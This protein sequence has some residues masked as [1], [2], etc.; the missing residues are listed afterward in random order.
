M[1]N[2]LCLAA[3]FLAAGAFGKTRTTVVVSDLHI[4]V[5][6]CGAKWCPSE[7]FRWPD[8]FAAFLRKI[9]VYGDVDLIFNGDTFELWQSLSRDCSHD[10]ANLGCSEAEALG[11]FIR[12]ADQHSPTLD[13]ILAFAARRDNRVVFVPGNHDAA[14]LYPSV[15]A[16]LLRRVKSDRV[17]V[18][19]EGYWIAPSDGAVYA[20]HGHQIG[21]DPNRMKRWPAPFLRDDGNVQYL[22]K[23]WGEQFVQDFYNAYE[24]RFPA[25]D[26][27]AG[28][29]SGLHYG[30]KKIGFIGTLVALGRFVKF[31]LLDESPE[32]LAQ[33]LSPQNKTRKWDVDATRLMGDELLTKGMG[34][35]TPLG[36][37]LDSQAARDAADVHIASLSK[38]ELTILCNRLYAR[39][40]KGE[41]VPQCVFSPAGLSPEGGLGAIADALLKDRDTKLIERV[42]AVDGQLKQA[43]E[44]RFGVFIYSHTHEPLPKFEL[45]ANGRLVAFAN[46]GA[47][48]HLASGKWAKDYESSHGSHGDVIAQEPEVIPDCF[49]FVVV[50]ADERSFPDLLRWNYDPA[51]GKGTIDRTSC[52]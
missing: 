4:G 9:D 43:A 3:L 11:R 35:D 37:L 42:T 34:E 39:S 21:R 7:D 29:S 15:R 17:S 28:E 52:Q 36:S 33:G 38:S 40:L 31:G 10:D 27:I 46:T 22:Q 20:E 30:F 32:Q 5:G 13:E 16:E 51:T 18:A 19:S 23:T 25:I 50:R 6:R 44:R 8:E 12:V 14:L 41:T 45:T 48:Q 26:N 24:E 47:W 1:K 2:A 49:T